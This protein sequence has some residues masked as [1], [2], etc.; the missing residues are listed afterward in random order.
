MLRVTESAAIRFIFRRNVTCVPH[1][2]LGVAQYKQA[3]IKTL[4]KRLFLNDI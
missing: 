2:H 4:R 3:G 1:H